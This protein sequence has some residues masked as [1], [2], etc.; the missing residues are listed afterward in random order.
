MSRA[1]HY[2]PDDTPDPVAESWDSITELLQL[3]RAWIA[4]SVVCAVLAVAIA[5]SFPTFFTLFR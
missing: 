4:F 2:F 5:F 1:P 3:V